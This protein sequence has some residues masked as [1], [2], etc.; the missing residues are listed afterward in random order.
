LFV[1]EDLFALQAAAQF[2]FRCWKQ[3]K[4]PS[5]QALQAVAQLDFGCWKQS[6]RSPSQPR[7]AA[8]QLS[9]RRWSKEIAPLIAP[10][11]NWS[12]AQTRSNWSG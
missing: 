6:K 9:I 2:D 11:A 10:A 8:P 1:R 7:Q 3:S 4:R 12:Q 5:S